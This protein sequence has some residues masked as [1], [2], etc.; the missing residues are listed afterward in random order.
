M[1][2]I[3]LVRHGET[4][5]NAEGRLQ[6]REDVPL[7]ERG[8]AQARQIARDVATHPWSLL[9]SSPLLRAWET[10]T[11]IGDELGMPTPLAVPPEVVERDYGEASGLSKAQAARRF[12]GGAP[13]AET[14]A[15]VWSRS[16]SV[17]DRLADTAGGGSVLLVGHGSVIK[18][19]LLG[20]SDGQVPT[21]D[22]RN[23]CLSLIW[24]TSTRDWRVSYHNETTH[25]PPLHHG[26]GAS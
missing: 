23:G 15:Q 6:G 12:P 7:N 8:R 25:Q 9:A 14:R 18:T 17:L 26:E 10:A 1:T 3:C 5:W 4:D 22:L 13:H 24:R 16:R 2:S 11:I 19:L 20:L 21:T